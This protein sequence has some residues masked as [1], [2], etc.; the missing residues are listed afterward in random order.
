M[1][2]TLSS[3]ST[4]G[5]RNGGGWQGGKVP[6]RPETLGLGVL[7]LAADGIGYGKHGLL[8]FTIAFGEIVV[9][10]LKTQT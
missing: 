2:D 1:Y 10:F 8:K 4:E 6:E 9:K 7:D 3:Q 5:H